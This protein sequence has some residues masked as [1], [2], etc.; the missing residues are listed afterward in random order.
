MTVVAVARHH[1]AYSFYW[2]CGWECLVSSFLLGVATC[3]SLHH[4]TSI[5]AVCAGRHKTYNI[6]SPASNVAV[7]SLTPKVNLVR[8]CELLIAHCVQLC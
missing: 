8:C 2:S 5:V 3:S 1:E 4:A 6:C 7:L